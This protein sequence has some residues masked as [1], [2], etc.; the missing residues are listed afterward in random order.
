MKQIIR[1]VKGDIKYILYTIVDGVG[2]YLTKNGREKMDEF[3]FEH[4]YEYY[5][6]NGDDEMGDD[7]ADILLGDIPLEHIKLRIAKETGLINW[8]ED[9]LEK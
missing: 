2:Y 8:Q 6:N 4:I 1:G 9:I 5:S 3:N 7:I